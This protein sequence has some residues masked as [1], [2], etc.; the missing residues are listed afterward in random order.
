MKQ[1]V[2]SSSATDSVHFPFGQERFL[3]GFRQRPAVV[4][5]QITVP[6]FCPEEEGTEGYP[7]KGSCNT[8]GPLLVIFLGCSRS[9]QRG[10][11]TAAPPKRRKGEK[12]HRTTKRRSS[13][14]RLPCGENI[15][16]GRT[17]RYTLLTSVMLPGHSRG[18]KSISSLLDEAV[19]GNHSETLTTVK[20][21]MITEKYLPTQGV[22]FRPEDRR[23]GRI[24]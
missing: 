13:A 7:L 24:S 1:N 12:P 10:R 17:T 14:F 23:T 20:D 16:A 5:R 11:T 6:V 2:P 8:K 21:L 19:L 3:F 22:P 15:D 18:H 9:A 4:G